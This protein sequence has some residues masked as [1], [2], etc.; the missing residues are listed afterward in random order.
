M[1][2]P[3]APSERRVWNRVARTVAPRRRPHGKGAAKPEPTASRED[4]AAMMRLPPLRPQQPTPFAGPV[5]RASD[6]SVRKGKVEIDRRL[7]LHGLTQAQARK[8][9]ATTLM[10][11][12]KQGE[13]CILVITGKGAGGEGVLRARL[14][15]WL[16]EGDLRPVVARLSQAHARHGGSGAWYV[17]LKG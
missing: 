16:G 13:K 17:F 12:T 2:R 11:A 5:P 3:L 15:D 8:T 7:D 1:S 14:P 4:F 6:K 9:L 10:R